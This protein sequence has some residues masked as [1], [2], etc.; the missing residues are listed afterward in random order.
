MNTSVNSFLPDSITFDVNEKVKSFI[1]YISSNITNIFS[2]TVSAFFSFVLMLL[3]IFYF[4]KDGASWRK[5]MVILSPLGD[6]ED[7]KII[8]RLALSVNAVIKG[9]LFI[10]LIQGILMGFGLW[11]FNISN[12]A[13]WG[14][15]AAIA[16]LIPTFGTSI[17]SIPAIIFLFITGDS[18]SAIGL[19]AWSTMLVGTIDNFLSPLIV[20]TK[21]NIPPLLILFSILGGISLLGPV[22]ILVGPLT[23]SLLYTLISIYRH[24]FKQNA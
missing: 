4:L 1:S 16:S 19:I 2:A 10:A 5:S 18:G 21:T 22:G 17:V 3:I 14:V 15:I 13:L 24:D 20:G 7:E 6:N 11:L 8:S 23:V 9:F 12:P